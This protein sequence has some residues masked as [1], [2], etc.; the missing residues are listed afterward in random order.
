MKKI[1]EKWNKRWKQEKIFEASPDNKKKF[2]GTFP[3]P[4]VNAYLHL[5]HFYSSMRLEALSRFKRMTGYNVLYAQAWHCT[6]SPIVNAARRIKEKEPKQIKIMKL[7]GF[8]D[9]E[10]ERFSEPVAWVAYFPKEAKKDFTDMGYS[11]DWRREFITTDLN[12]RYSRFIEWQF[13]RLREKK[14]VLKGKFPVVWD[15]VENNPVGDHARLEGEG[16]TPQEYVLVKHKLDDKW[17]VSATLRPD[18]IM[19]VTNLFVNPSSELV[20]AKVDDEIWIVSEK[21]AKEL[22]F[23]DKDIK[24]IKKIKG[25]SLIGRKVEEFAGNSVIILPASFVTTDVG[26]GIV[27]SVPSDSADDLIALYDI[28]NNE[29]LCQKFSLNPKEVKNIKPIAVIDIPGYGKIPAADAIKKLGIK[30][31]EDS[32]KLKKAKDMLYKDGFYK[33]KL[34]SLYKNKFSKNLAGKSVADSKDMIKDELVKSKYG[35]I[36]YQLTG[37][38]VARSLGECVVKIVEDQWFLAYGDE[39]WTKQAH[40]CLDQMKLYPEKARPQFEY[41]LDW[42]RNWACTRELGLGTKLPWDKK[43]LIESLSDSTIY[44]AYYTIAHKIKDIPLEKIDDAF[45]DYVLLGKNTKIKVDKNL[46]DSLREEFEYWYPMDFRTTGKDLI[47][48]HMSFCIFNHTAVFPKKH[49]PRAFSLNGH[50]AID[51]EKMSK[52]KGNFI[53][54]RQAYED[55][56]ADASRFT[57]LS[58]GEG[59]DDA[60]FDTEMAKSMG[61]KI[62]LLLD[63][64]KDNY[65][66]G[67]TKKLAIDK[68][69]EN[70]IDLIIAEATDNYENALLRSALQSAYFD[71]QN[72]LKWYMRRTVGNPNKDTINKFIETQALLLAPVMPF[73]CEE[74]WEAIGKKG[75]ISLAKWPKVKKVSVDNSEDLV[76]DTL[77]DINSVLS[78]VNIKPKKVTLFVADDWKYELYSLLKKQLETSRDFSQMMGVVMK[79]S[80][81][82][83]H[84]KE[85]IKIIQKTLKSG[86]GIVSTSKKEYSVL[87]QSRAFFENELN[88]KVEVTKEKES[89]E[90]KAK[91]AMPGKAAILVE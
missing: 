85:V 88:L 26:T 48:N 23:Q 12:K 35:D 39:K 34:N 45:F 29:K 67:R 61:P 42:L 37:K 90:N 82:K 53:T 11:V 28:Q 1:Q 16:E 49:W 10:I 24:I 4:Y 7:Q 36:Y 56:G 79:N 87:E 17:I 5:G 60:N 83:K 3:Y 6:G 63:F 9:K 70:K 59:M 50:V 21:T 18:T 27:H 66:K 14:Y 68:W 47:Q 62:A 54:M 51:G 32:E 75:F 20:E 81:M 8:S 40:D 22:S 91:Q 72:S 84:S 64:A 52:S 38:V 2:F 41:V 57:A 77:A 78:L 69:L 73:I 80:E 71:M 44:M 31:Q 74:I 55:Y 19:G 25:R 86:I 58:G 13:R 30:S 46:G 76:K 43:W 65:D 89:K 15:P 33:G